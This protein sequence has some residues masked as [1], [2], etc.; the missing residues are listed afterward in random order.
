MRAGLTNDYK[1][2]ASDSGLQGATA[3]LYVMYM[4]ERWPDGEMEGYATEWA[5][6]FQAGYEFN[7]S[8]TTGQR[9]LMRIQRLLYPP[10]GAII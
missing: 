2:I 7:A 10:E 8:D 5:G 4:T 6:R 3:K 9:V 1:R